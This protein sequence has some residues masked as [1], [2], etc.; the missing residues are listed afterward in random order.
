MESPDSIVTAKKLVTLSLAIGA[1]ERILQENET[2]KMPGEGVSYRGYD[3]HITKDNVA[4]AL[5]KMEPP[6]RDY[7][8]K[9]DGFLHATTVENFLEK[10]PPLILLSI[11]V[12][13]VYTPGRED[14][15]MTLNQW[16]VRNGR[17][18]RCDR[19]GILELFKTSW[20]NTIIPIIKTNRVLSYHVFKA[21]QDEIEVQ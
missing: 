13:A 21:F 6:F 4:Q 16:N 2:P 5:E 7:R 10:C 15:F 14:F 19:G 3:F 17:S 9:V 20:L 11:Y 1:D 18:M 12:K 8:E